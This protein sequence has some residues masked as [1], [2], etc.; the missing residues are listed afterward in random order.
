MELPG[1]SEENLTPS[2]C[3]SDIPSPLSGVHKEVVDA[4]A[5]LPSHSGDGSSSQKV[6]DSYKQFLNSLVKSGSDKAFTIQKEYKD[7]LDPI[8]E[9]V[10]EGNGSSEELVDYD[11]SDNSQNS[12]TPF[13]S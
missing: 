2:S 7:L 5:S 13:L 1:T 11:D 8:A 4:L 12:D 3:V 9:N 10:N 6:A